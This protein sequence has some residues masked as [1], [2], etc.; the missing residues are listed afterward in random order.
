MPF[1]LCAPFSIDSTSWIFRA[2]DVPRSDYSP[3][4]SFWAHLNDVVKMNDSKG[5]ILS[6]GDRVK[7]HWNFDNKIHEGHIF[8]ISGN[9]AE[10]DIFTRKISIS[11]PAKITKI[12]DTQ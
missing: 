4:G 3:N 9:V 2:L 8:R 12:P 10:I 1:T 5:N 7:I 6:I 11:N